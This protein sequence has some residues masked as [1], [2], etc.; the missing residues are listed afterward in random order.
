MDADIQIRTVGV[1]QRDLLIRM[2]D[3]FEPLGGA[4]GLPPWGAQPRRA[5][6]GVALGSRLNLA[7]VSPT[8]EAVGH[9]F[10]VVDGPDSAEL[11]VFVHQQYRRRGVGTALLN[12]ALEWGSRSG[13]RH[14]WT[15]TSFDNQ[16]ALRL[17]SRCGFRLANEASPETKLE[18]DLPE[19]RPDLQMPY[20]GCRA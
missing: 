1:S 7:A 15:L 3:R 18:I 12:A 11:A 4:L 20:A 5:W 10:L 14:V 13:L 17:Q 2:Y 6:I 8:G 16:A 9:C 19:L